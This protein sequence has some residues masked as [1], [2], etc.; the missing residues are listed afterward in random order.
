VAIAGRRT[1]PYKM[2]LYLS[3][4]RMKLKTAVWT[5]KTLSARPKIIMANYL[6]GENLLW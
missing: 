6:I 5:D 3:C 1:P 4:M 2:H